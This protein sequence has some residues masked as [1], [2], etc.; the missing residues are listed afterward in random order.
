[1]SCY[2][3]PL[4]QA[5]NIE[6]GSDYT[7]GGLQSEMPRKTHIQPLLLDELAIAKKNN[8]FRPF[9]CEVEYDANDGSVVITYSKMFEAMFVFGA[10]QN[11]YA[12]ITGKVLCLLFE[13]ERKEY[14]R[15]FISAV[16]RWDDRE[17]K[18]TRHNALQSLILCFISVRP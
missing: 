11:S 9:N 4:S 10:S 5:A 1:M 7:W 17:I 2:V 8:E 14:Y 3:S 13:F 6:G 15:I 16:R 12:P 18:K